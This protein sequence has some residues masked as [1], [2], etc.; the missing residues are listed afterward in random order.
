MAGAERHALRATQLHAGAIF[1]PAAGRSRGR[2]RQVPVS[3]SLRRLVEE[4]REEWHHLEEKI[5]RITREIGMA[6]A[7]DPG[8]AR[9]MAVPGIGP[10]SASALVAAIGNGGAFSKG[11]DFAAWLGLVPRQFSTGGRP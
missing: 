6:A 3:P 8:Y 9:L 10:I 1:G 11:R 5:D 2:R 4:L 7:A